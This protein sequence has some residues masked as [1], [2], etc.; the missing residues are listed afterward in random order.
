MTD[1]DFPCILRITTSIGGLMIEKLDHIPV[2]GEVVTVG[3][4]RLSAHRVNGNRIK[5]VCI[6]ILKDRW[7]IRERRRK[8]QR[9]TVKKT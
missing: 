6:Q 2:Q 3:N 1:W 5:K 8:K 9:K 4:I 7:K